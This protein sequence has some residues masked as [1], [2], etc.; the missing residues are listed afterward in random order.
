VKPKLDAA[1]RLLCTD[2]ELTDIL[3]AAERYPDRRKR[4]LARAMISVLVYCGL[5][6]QELTDLKVGDFSAGAKTLLV[7]CGKG[8]KSGVLY[9]PSLRRRAA[10]VAG[11]ARGLHPRL[12]VGQNRGRRLSDDG[13]RRLWK[14]SRRW[15]V[16]RTLPT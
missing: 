1:H 7:R 3:A 10:G 6:A 5:R 2:E 16:T 11:R 13:L 12:D 15:R 8:G 4:A 14:R 9:P